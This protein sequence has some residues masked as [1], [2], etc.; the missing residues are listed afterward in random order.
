M[1]GFVSPAKDLDIYRIS[2]PSGATLTLQLTPTTGA[3]HD[4]ELRN[5]TGAVLAASRLGTGRV[6]SISWTNRAA[7]A[8][9]VYP[10]VIWISGGTGATDGAY[11]LETAY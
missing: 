6:D 5:L 3:N 2:V 11:T 9:D 8:V 4:L 10:R 7:A 1:S